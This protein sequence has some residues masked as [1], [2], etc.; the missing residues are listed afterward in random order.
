MT[1]Y[2]SHT[3]LETQ[4]CKRIYQEKISGVKKY[5]PELEKLLEQLREDD[6]V[7]VCR[8]D[9][10]ARSTHDL[11][12]IAERIEKAGAHFYSLAEPW[13]NTTS[14]AGRML[15]TVFA[16]IAEFERDLIRERTSAGRMTAKSRGVKFGRPQKIRTEHKALIDH[17]LS[18]GK[19]IKEIALTFSIHPSTIYRN[20]TLD[21]NLLS[22]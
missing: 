17:L 12:D 21:Q 6:T 3:L 20:L 13:A 15:M 7:I 4:E 18:E 22:T 16:G 10:L 14:H 11:L 9:R 5:R 19:S 2:F 8:L 1:Q